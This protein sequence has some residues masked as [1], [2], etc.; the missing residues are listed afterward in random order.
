MV[1][2][3][4]LTLV[5]VY[6]MDVSYLSYYFSPLVSMWYLIVYATLAI[7]SQYNDSIVFLL[8]KILISMGALTWFMTETWMLEAF[9]VFLEQIFSIRWSAREWS[10]RVTLDLWIVYFG[11]LLAIAVTRIQAHRLTDHHLWPMAVKVAAGASALIML[12]F[13]AFELTQ[14]SKFT[15]NAWHPYISFL[16]IAAFVILRNASS[17]LRSCSSR[18]FAFIG[19]CSLETFLIQFHLW[20]AG[21]TKGILLLLPGTSWRPIN[22]V[23]STIV[24]IYISDHV[25]RATGELTTWICGGKETSLPTS[26]H[27][28]VGSAPLTTDVYMSKDGERLPVEPDTPIRPTRRWVDRLAEGASQQR[29]PGYKVWYGGE[30]GWKPGVKMRLAVW[31]GMMWLANSLWTDSS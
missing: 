23:I 14:E 20:L 7:G 9:F 3:N 4:L 16:P 11:M 29:S 15:Y 28:H 30:S 21:D 5:L 19:R 2:L 6:T 12:W 10:F 8:S 18:A 17:S 1:R 22:F 31:M 27:R 13:F 25:S 26:T 24:F